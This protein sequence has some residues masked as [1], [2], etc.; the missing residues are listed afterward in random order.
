MPNSATGDMGSASQ[1]SSFVVLVLGWFLAFLSHIRQFGFDDFSFLIYFQAALA[2]LA[3]IIFYTV[4][5]WSVEEE[6]HQILRGLPKFYPHVELSIRV[7]ILVLLAFSTTAFADLMNFFSDPIAGLF[8]GLIVLFCMLV[9]WD[10]VVCQGDG[11]AKNLAKVFRVYDFSGL[12]IAITA[13]VC[14]QSHDRLLIGCSL[15]VVAGGVFTYF[16]CQRQII[17]KYLGRMCKRNSVK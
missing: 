3:T 7:L 11:D 10:V 5:L 4:G 1:V 13:L 2:L 9:L 17:M 6:H 8:Q 12:V 15:F 14:Y 16:H